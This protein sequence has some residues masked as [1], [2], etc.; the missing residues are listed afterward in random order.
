MDLLSEEISRFSNTVYQQGIRYGWMMAIEFL[1]SEEADKTQ[2]N[3]MLT[4]REWAGIMLE[5]AEKMKHE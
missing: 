2:E 5:K 1:L 4:A 3:K